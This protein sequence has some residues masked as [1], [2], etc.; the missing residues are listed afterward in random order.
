VS[1]ERGSF[2][3]RRFVQQSHSGG[4]DQESLEGIPFDGSSP[5][6]SQS[7]ASGT[8]KLTA[9]R[10]DELSSPTRDKPASN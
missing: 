3:I 1:G 5:P 10:V 4:L 6:S 8:G 9:P 2:A 7:T